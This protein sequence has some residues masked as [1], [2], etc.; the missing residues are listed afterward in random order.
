[1]S[2]HQLRTSRPLVARTIRRLSVPIILA[3]LAI[4][5]IVTIGV[6]PLELVTAAALGIAESRRC[7]IVQGG[8]ARR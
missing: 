7:R 3:W 4:A 2:N 6:P 8:E 1:M 5:G